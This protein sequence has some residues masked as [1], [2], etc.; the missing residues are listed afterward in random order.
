[1]LGSIPPITSGQNVSA[2]W[3]TRGGRILE[4]SICVSWLEGEISLGCIRAFYL[5]GTPPRVQTPLCSCQ[6]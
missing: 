4:E 1:M 6:H 3:S 2:F 5:P